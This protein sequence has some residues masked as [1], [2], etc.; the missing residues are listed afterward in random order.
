MMKLFVGTN[1]TLGSTSMRAFVVGMHG[2]FMVSLVLSLVAAVFS[3]V[4][5]REDR[6]PLPS[7]ESE[8]SAIHTSRPN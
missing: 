2:A 8:R 5:G 4:R 3:F 7:Q 6:R 1:I